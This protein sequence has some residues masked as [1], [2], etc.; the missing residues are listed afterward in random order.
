VNTSDIYKTTLNVT[1]NVRTRV[2]LTE[3]KVA[4]AMPKTNVSVY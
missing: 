4:F 2:T 1:I 3:T